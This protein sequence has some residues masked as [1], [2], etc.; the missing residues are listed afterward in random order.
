MT[1]RFG[2]YRIIHGDNGQRI[3]MEGYGRRM[4]PGKPML[5]EKEI[6]IALP[7]GAR[8][9]SAEVEG[10]GGAELPG[11]F[12]IAP[13]PPIVPLAGEPLRRKLAAS[14]RR[15]WQDNNEAAYSS[16]DA[17]PKEPGR[18][19]CSG[20]LRK[21]AYASVS[22]CPFSYRPLSG[23]LIRY[24]AARITVHYSTPSRGT[25]RALEIE[26]L[27]RDRSADGR[28]SEL[29]VNYEQVRD[30]YDAEPTA[31]AM[32]AATHD[33]VIITAD[34][35]AAA[36]SQTGFIAWK[37][38]LGYCVRT[39]LTTDPLIAYQPGADLAAKIRNF[40]RTYYAAWGIQYVLLVGDI[41]TVPMRYCFPNPDDHS[42]DPENFG[43]H[44]GS[45]PTDWYY[46]DLSLSDAESWDLDGD[47][48]LGEYLHD[49]PD[50][51]AEVYVGRIPTSDAGRIIYTFDKL[52]DFER[53]DG[54]WKNQALQPGSILFYENQDYQGY[55]KIDGSTLLNQIEADLMSGWT[56]S[57]YTEKAGLSPSAFPWP[58]VSAA[59]FI[60][61]W[62]TGQ[63]GVV[64]WSGH[65]APWGVCRTVWEWDDGDG[66]P[67]TD[68]SDGMGQPTLIDQWCAFED[69]YPSI[70]FAVSCYVGYPEA[71]GV[72]N[73]G[74]DLLTDPGLGAAAG[75]VC[76]TRPAWISADVINNP[77]GAESVC[78]EFNRHGISEGDRLGEALYNAKHY[79]YQNYGWD[80]YAEHINQCNF[81]LYGDPSM[82]RT[83][84]TT[85]VRDP[86]HPE[87]SEAA[88]LLQNYPNPFNP[89]TTIRF[90][91]PR[92]VHVGLRVYNVKGELVATL[93]DEHMTGGQK[94]ID[95]NAKDDR[96]AAVASG[97]YFYRLIAGDFEQTKKM[98]LLR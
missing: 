69:D 41:A 12:R 17:Y 28:A 98:A 18:L 21:Y 67:E 90:E 31:A 39:V 59:A 92:A 64:N 40:L 77:G 6:L 20:T 45:V 58:A 72:G 35:L 48:Y 57:R 63:Y 56:V 61:D 76:S 4:E 47:G 33:Y 93:L 16:D 38:T 66:V 36:V 19:T 44:G 8:V 95:W 55:P 85:A 91:L 42:H 13:S 2:Q 24:D 37:S 15:E 10:I 68:G 78:Y 14:I 53:D 81:N 1:V 22:V 11:F 88:L 30:L 96:G 80:H 3:V 7:P 74:I 79:C 84:I 82:M 34:S 54:A 29:F 89:V 43:N 5:P 87:V 60:G 97:I 52:V 73:L 46:A 75:I 32:P 26:R 23:R 62:Q 83:G 50:F 70:V 27:L 94:E 65:G 71:A 86:D 51:L 49:S 25:P 9:R